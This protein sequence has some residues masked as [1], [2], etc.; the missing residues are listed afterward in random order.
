MILENGNP[1]VQFD[2]INDYLYSS[3]FS[4]SQPN[5]IFAVLKQTRTNIGGE[6]FLQSTGNS[7]LFFQFGTEDYAIFAGLS[8]QATSES[9]N[10]N[11]NL[12]YG[13]FNTSSSELQRNNDT[14]YSGDVSNGNW[15]DLYISGRGGTTQF[16]AAKFQEIII[17][18]GNKSTDKNGIKTN[19]ND[20][21][22]IY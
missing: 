12:H 9:T 11:Q 10:T 19:I 4:Q 14:E 1:S 17:F 7:S 3:T 18:S 5:T 21:Y 8:L 2:G 16:S 22:S 15:N 13:L 20:F 6:S